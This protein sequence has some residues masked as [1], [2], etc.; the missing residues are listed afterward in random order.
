M[1]TRAERF[2]HGR[3]LYGGPLTAIAPAGGQSGRRVVHAETIPIGVEAAQAGDIGWGV[4]GAGASLGPLTTAQTQRVT[5]T[6][7]SAS[8]RY[9]PNF[10]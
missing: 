10:L 4:G 6:T 9:G 2:V 5:C 7:D 8:R 1:P 3:V